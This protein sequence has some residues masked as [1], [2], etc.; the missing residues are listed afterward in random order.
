MDR[1]VEFLNKFITVRGKWDYNTSQAIDTLFLGNFP[2]SNNYLSGVSV[3]SQRQFLVEWASGFLTAFCEEL[4]KEKEEEKPL[5]DR[6]LKTLLG[7]E[8]FDLAKNTLDKPWDEVALSVYADWL[9]ENRGRA[10]EAERVR[11]MIIKDGDIVIFTHPKGMPTEDISRYYDDIE[12]WVAQYNL[13]NK[14]SLSWMLVHPD[15]DVQILQ[16]KKDA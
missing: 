11:K 7:N 4:N 2:L 1:W 13:E 3:S 9:E 10:A 16:R 15:F 8:G 12:K 6:L 5:R 14:K